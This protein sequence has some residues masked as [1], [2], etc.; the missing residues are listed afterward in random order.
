MVIL[1]LESGTICPPMIG[2]TQTELNW[3]STFGLGVGHPCLGALGA[4][5][6]FCTQAP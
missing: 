6:A 3:L 4:G 5:G 2:R 1:S